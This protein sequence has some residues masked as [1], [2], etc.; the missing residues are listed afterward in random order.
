MAL[1]TVPVSAGSL[2]VEVLDGTTAPVLAIHGNSSYRRLWN[3]AAAL[4]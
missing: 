3:L 2:A 4:A 1:H